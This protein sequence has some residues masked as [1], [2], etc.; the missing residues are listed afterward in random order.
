MDFTRSVTGNIGSIKGGKTDVFPFIVAFI[1]IF[2]GFVVFVYTIMGL[3]TVM[4][5]IIYFLA[6]GDTILG[7][8]ELYLFLSG[9]LISIV[10]FLVGL[11]LLFKNA[12]KRAQSK[13][14]FALWHFGLSANVFLLLLSA[15]VCLA[16]LMWLI[17][18]SFPLLYTGTG[19]GITYGVL[20]VFLVWRTVIYFKRLRRYV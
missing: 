11:Y 6:G 2:L 20:F 10:I 4:N 1:P 15:V 7:L 8:L 5:H 19:I 18:T 17:F 13:R 16:F 3:A 12:P 9:N 14:E